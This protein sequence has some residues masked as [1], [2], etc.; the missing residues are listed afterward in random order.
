MVRNKWLLPLACLGFWLIAPAVESQTCC[1]ACPVLTSS[2]QVADSSTPPIGFNPR[3]PGGPAPTQG[4]VVPFSD[5]H[6]SGPEGFRVPDCFRVCPPM[7]TGGVASQSEWVRWPWLGDSG[8]LRMIGTSATVVPIYDPVIGQAGS[9]FNFYFVVNNGGTVQCSS[10]TCS[11]SPPVPLHARFGSIRGQVL[12]RSGVP[13]AGV[14]VAAYPKAGS[15]P[16]GPP[17]QRAVVTDANGYFDFTT[18]KAELLLNENKLAIPGR[19]FLPGVTLP[20]SNR[21]GLLLCGNVGPSC[22]GEVQSPGSVSREFYVLAGYRV[23]PWGERQA[24][25]QRL[26]HQIDKY[27]GGR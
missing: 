10:T 27:L 20:A 18:T 9:V 25:E 5:F 2:V 4:C 19:P 24:A 22:S 23:R 13:L 12:H 8:P 1:P 3:P 17:L 15:P 11:T 14:V 21:W 26:I 16:L 7:T 6:Q